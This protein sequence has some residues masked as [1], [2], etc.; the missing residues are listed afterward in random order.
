MEVDLTC[1][2]TPS[3]QVVRQA[4]RGVPLMMVSALGNLSLWPVTTR[5]PLIA[6]GM[7]GSRFGMGAPLAVLETVISVSVSRRRRPWRRCCV[8]RCGRRGW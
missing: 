5:L 6:A 8:H 2:L 3:V 7:Q 4:Q 1:G